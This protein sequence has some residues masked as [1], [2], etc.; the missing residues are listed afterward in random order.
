MPMSGTGPSTGVLPMLMVPRVGASRPAMRRI[1][2]LLPQ[3]LGPDD[4][5]RLADAHLDGEGCNRLH[6]SRATVRLLDPFET[7]RPSRHLAKPLPN[8]L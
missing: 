1:S 3:P 6:P 7:D 4:A 2:V 5:D 8:P